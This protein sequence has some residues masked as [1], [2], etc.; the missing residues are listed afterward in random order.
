M[1]VITIIEGV[2]CRLDYLMFF[3]DDEGQ[4]RICKRNCRAYYRNAKSVTLICYRIIIDLLYPRGDRQGQ[5]AQSTPV[6]DGDARR[7]C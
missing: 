1:R 5:W 3:P 4:S 6:P 7:E 2:I